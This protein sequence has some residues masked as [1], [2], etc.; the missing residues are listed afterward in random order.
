MR[1]G[2]HRLAAWLA[3]LAMTLQALW[4]LLAHA[5]PRDVVLVPLCTVDGETHYAE[6]DVG[7][8]RSDPAAE[9]CPQCWIGTE[10]ALA[11]TH[12][13]SVRLASARHAVIA[14]RETTA[15]AKAVAESARP[16][17]PPLPS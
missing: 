13:S 2:H 8:S 1:M 5:K 16:R 3:V 6:L 11:A 9:H 17:G 10:R 4:P 12:L 14:A 7:G 15:P